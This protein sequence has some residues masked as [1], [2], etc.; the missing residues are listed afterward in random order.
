[1]AKNN[2]ARNNNVSEQQPV[3]QGE[4]FVSHEDDP[5]LSYSE[6]GK[7][8]GRTHT[9]I[10]NWV[11]EGLLRSFRDPSGLHRVRKSELTRFYGGTALAESRPISGEAI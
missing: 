3:V 9:T 1:M 4:P 7:L 6:A 2:R 11:R 5:M 8:V 10:K